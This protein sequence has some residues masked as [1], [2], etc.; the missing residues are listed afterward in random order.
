MG[1]MQGSAEQ[2]PAENSSYLPRYKV[3]F[4]QIGM[5]RQA[6]SS[7]QRS[8][9]LACS[10]PGLTQGWSHMADG[11]VSYQLHVCQRFNPAQEVC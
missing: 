1:C 4:L 8:Q 2:Q 10:M 6:E 11:Q 7:A 5:P 9:N 3:P